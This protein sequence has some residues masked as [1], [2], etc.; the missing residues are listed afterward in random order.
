MNVKSYVTEAD[1]AMHS[2]INLLFR[3]INLLLYVFCDEQ[4]I[5]KC[6]TRAR[7]QVGAPL[8]GSK[9]GTSGN[10][11]PTKDHRI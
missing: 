8:A 7:A 4:G 10:F 11:M 9:G 2:F 3:K 1:I 5:I 6:R